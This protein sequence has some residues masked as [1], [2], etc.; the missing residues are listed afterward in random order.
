MLIGTTST[1]ISGK[2]RDLYSICR[3]RWDVATYNWKVHDGKM[4]II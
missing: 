2:L 3:C 4:E 1:G